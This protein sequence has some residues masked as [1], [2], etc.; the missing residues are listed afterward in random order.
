MVAM[1]VWSPRWAPCRRRN[2]AASGC[3]RAPLWHDRRR[4]VG[5]A[6]CELNSEE[7]C[8]MLAFSK[9]GRIAIADRLGALTGKPFIR[10]GI[11]KSRPDLREGKDQACR[12]QGVRQL[13]AGTVIDFLFRGE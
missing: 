11:A 3:A 13:E 4:P 7:N 8:S 10:R 6:D 1:A 9:F 2:N 5:L 12:L